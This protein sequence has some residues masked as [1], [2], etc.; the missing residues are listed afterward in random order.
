MRASTRLRPLVL[1]VAVAAAAVAPASAAA[2]EVAVPALDATFAAGPAGWTSTSSCAPLCS[3]ANAVDPNAGASE[4][5]SAAVI[6]TSLGGLLGGLAAG[7]STWTSPSFTWTNASPAH[8]TL[9]FA[10]KAAIGGLL[11]VGGSASARVQLH[12]LTSGDLTTIASGALS[13]AEGSFVPQTFAVDPGLLRT[14]HAY[15]LLI[16]TSLSA[17]ALLS[18]I[19]VAY[20][21]I[22]LTATVTLQDADNGGGGAAGSG[23]APAA[24]AAAAAART[25]LRLLSPRVVRFAPGRPF[26]LR[27]RASRAGAGVRRLAVVVRVG[28]TVRRVMTGRDGSAL[29]H[30]VRRD[31]APVRVAFRAGAATA[32]TLLRP[33]GGP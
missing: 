4:P 14:G 29:I 20:D 3:V 6:Y 27:V 8:A 15:R 5:G 22:T 12:D 24:P 7:T 11:N 9:S 32:S 25:A 19:R 28:T 31:R 33:E 16:T 2:T 21:D 1:A 17:A 23:G 30:L 26:T 10:R 13:T 18:G